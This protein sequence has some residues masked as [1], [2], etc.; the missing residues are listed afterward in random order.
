MS[1]TSNRSSYAPTARY[2]EA[3]HHRAELEIA[4][5]ENESLRRRI[6][7]LERSLSS[8]RESG[9]NRRRSD[10]TSTGVSIQSAAVGDT[11]QHGST[12][13]EDM[14]HVGESA[15]SLGVGGGL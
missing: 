14:V 11:Q 15:S 6:R 2:E 9:A 5:R 8:R 1:P 12:G 4:K 10:S 7:E 13:N 3:A